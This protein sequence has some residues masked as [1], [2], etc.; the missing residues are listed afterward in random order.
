MSVNAIFPFE[1]FPVSRILCTHY[2]FYVFRCHL[3][4]YSWCDRWK[5]ALIYAKRND[6]WMGERMVRKNDGLPALFFAVSRSFALCSTAIT[7]HLAILVARCLSFSLTKYYVWL[8]EVRFEFPFWNIC[9]FQNDRM[10]KGERGHWHVSVCTRKYVNISMHKKKQKL[11][12]RQR[13]VATK[14]KALTLA[15]IA[16]TIII[17]NGNNNATQQKLSLL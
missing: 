12:E 1:Y 14:F 10:R 11:T 6:G 5:M 4:F 13:K 15:A 7:K 2:I 9:S 17:N 16:I 8:F 3:P